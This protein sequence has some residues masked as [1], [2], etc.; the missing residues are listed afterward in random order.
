[1]KRREEKRKI[2]ITDD[3]TRKKSIQKMN[4]SRIGIGSKY[5]MNVF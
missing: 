3:E 4:E 2:K 1:V 5:I